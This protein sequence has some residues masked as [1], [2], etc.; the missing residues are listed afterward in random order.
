MTGLTDFAQRIAATL[1][2]LAL[3]AAMFTSYFAHPGVSTVTGVLA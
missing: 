2:A 3:T 1:G